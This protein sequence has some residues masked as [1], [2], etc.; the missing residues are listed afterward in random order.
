M[1]AST[2]RLDYDFLGEELPTTPIQLEE[3]RTSLISEFNL[4]V[5]LR[6]ADTVFKFGYLREIECSIGGCGIFTKEK[7]LSQ[8]NLNL[9]DE[10]IKEARKEA[11]A[12]FHKGIRK[13]KREFKARLIA[14]CRDSQAMWPLWATRSDKNHAKNNKHNNTTFIHNPEQLAGIVDLTYHQEQLK[15][16]FFRIK[17]KSCMKL[18]NSLMPKNLEAELSEKSNYRDHLEDC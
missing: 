3:A 14:E 10:V 11:V 6:Q 8:P 9:E 7:F 16:K 18:K 2:G 4:R 1:Q 15:K 12:A 5:V 17:H 13:A